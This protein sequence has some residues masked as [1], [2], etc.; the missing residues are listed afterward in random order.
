M[1]VH[2]SRHET[3]RNRVEKPEALDRTVKEEELQDLRQVL[4]EKIP[5]LNGRLLRSEACMYTMTPDEHL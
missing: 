5:K 1:A 3:N 2:V 4:Q